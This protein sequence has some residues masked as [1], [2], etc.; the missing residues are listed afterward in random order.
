MLLTLS[1][2]SS[3]INAHLLVTLPLLQFSVH[4]NAISTSASST[5]SKQQLTSLPIY[6]ILLWR[7]K[8]NRRTAVT[9]F[10]INKCIDFFRIN[11]RYIKEFGHT[12]THVYNKP[13]L[14]EWLMDSEAICYIV[15]IGMTYTSCHKWI[16][17]NLTNHV[18]Y[19]STLIRIVL[20]KFKLIGCT[21]LDD[22]CIT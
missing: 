4:L 7:W 13:F 10:C 18:W 21:S 3:F 22:S 12:H 6:K 11:E 19:R 16:L 1:F 17:L 15:A 8:N 20:E 14:L 9:H 2:V 5:R